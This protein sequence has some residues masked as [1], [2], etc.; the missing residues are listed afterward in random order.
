MR[1][2]RSE[3]ESFVYKTQIVKCSITY[4]SQQGFQLEQV[5]E[6]NKQRKIFQGRVH[7]HQ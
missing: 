3:E 5:S 1:K 4:I 6:L 7:V 2:L